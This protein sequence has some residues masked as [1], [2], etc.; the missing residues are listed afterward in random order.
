VR[1]EIATIGT[2]RA[3]R[4]QTVGLRSEALIRPLSVE[5]KIVEDADI[6]LKG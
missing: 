2:S 1:V 3:I 5:R 4:I 6:S